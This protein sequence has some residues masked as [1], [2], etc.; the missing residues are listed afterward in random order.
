MSTYY[1]I[2]LT[3]FSIIATM[4]VIDN[5][6]ADYIILLFKIVRVNIERF[7]WRI[8]FHPI[9]FTNPLARWLMMKK[10]TKIIE[11]NE[12]RKESD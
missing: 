11:K 1:L 12:S 4:I 10:Y 7:F 3:L 9:M 6:V 8:R 2:L 5:N